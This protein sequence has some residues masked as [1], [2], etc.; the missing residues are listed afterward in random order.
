MIKLCPNCDSLKFM[1]VRSNTVSQY[2]YSISES[3]TSVYQSQLVTLDTEDTSVSI[4]CSKCK[5]VIIDNKGFY[6]YFSSRRSHKSY[7]KELL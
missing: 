6:E 2:H 1:E 4:I 5:S 7:D 3:G